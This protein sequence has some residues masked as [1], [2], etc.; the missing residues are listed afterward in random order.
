MTIKENIK[1]I[2]AC[3]FSGF[4]DEYIETAT[5]KIMG[6]INAL[7][8]GDLI[9]REALKEATERLYHETKDGIV[10]FGI[11]KAYSLIDKAPAVDTFTFDD[12]KKGIEVGR[13]FGQSEG[14]AN[15]KS[16]YEFIEILAHYVPEEICPYPEYRGKPYYSIHYKENGEDFG[17]FG[18]YNPEVLSRYLREYFF[19]RPDMREE[20]DT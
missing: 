10:K 3:N 7:P 1:S 17:G 11:E 18:T 20:V 13:L 16:K 9:S 6:I 19:E 12:M 14:R 2:L 15:N 8:P 5:D 4:K